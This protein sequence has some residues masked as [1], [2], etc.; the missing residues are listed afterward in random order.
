[1]QRAPLPDA[2]MTI[3]T[4]LKMGDARLLKVAAPVAQFGTPALRNLVAD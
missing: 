3:R 2:L 4:I 1:M